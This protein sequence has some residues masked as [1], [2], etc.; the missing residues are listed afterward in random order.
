MFPSSS[1][2]SS[3]EEERGS[4]SEHAPRQRAA[5]GD[6]VMHPVHPSTPSRRPS[7]SGAS[8]SLSWLTPATRVLVVLKKDGGAEVEEALWRTV[9]ALRDRGCACFVE[10]QVARLISGVRRADG[11]EGYVQAAPAALG[12]GLAVGAQWSAD[13]AVSLGGDG[14][15]LWLSA[16]HGDSPVPPVLTV[17]L[18]TLGALTNVPESLLESTLRDAL[19]GHSHL[20]LRQ[21]LACRITRGSA[22]GAASAALLSGGS[23]N[24][25]GCSEREPQAG[26]GRTHCVLNEVLV[27]RGGSSNLTELEVYCDGVFVTRVSGDGLIVATPSGS[28]AYSLAAG[29]PI[30]HPG[31]ESMVLT[32]VCPHSLSFRPTILPAYVEVTLRVLSPTAHVSCDGRCAGELRR[33]DSVSVWT[34]SHPLPQI[35]SGGGETGDWLRALGLLH[36]NRRGGAYPGR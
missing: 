13:L 21:R 34:S 32:P 12:G 4:L 35:V 14:T 23:S 5:S 15:L 24:G 18:G 17:A 31:M 27:N 7:A 36:F 22:H 20:M 9:A 19:D 29:G 10:P 33:G 1:S 26:E 8:V 2:Y 25:D 30:V 6:E 16:L 28:T 11:L 3:G